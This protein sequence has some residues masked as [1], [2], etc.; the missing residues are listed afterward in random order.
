[1]WPDDFNFPNAEPEHPEAD[2]AAF[3]LNALDGPEHRAVAQHVAQCLHCQEVLLGFQGMAARLVESAPQTPLPPGLKARVLAAV[4][5][6]YDARP[7]PAMRAP[8]AA[9]PPPDRRWSTRRLRRWLA[10]AAIGA[11]SLLLAASAGFI[12][13]QQR[14]I[15]RLAAAAPAAAVAGI[16]AETADGSTAPTGPR[17]AS[18]RSDA[19]AAFAPAAV[20]GD[21]LFTAPNQDADAR[22]LN[23]ANAEQVDLVRREMADVVEATVLSAQSETKKLAMFSPMGT[24]PEAKGV[25]M[26]DPGGHQGVLMVSGMPVDSYQIWLARADKRMLVGRIVV[27][28]DNDGNGV[29]RLEL[30]ES[31]FDFQQVALLPDERN[32]P[33]VPNGEKF[34]TA[35]IIGGPPLPSLNR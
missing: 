28:A 3:A 12:V 2:L 27:N 14:E 11:L 5:R 29:Q 30:D 1:M 18:G 16:A 7:E 23:A 6:P 33:T 25:L 8:A 21:P 10:P 22:S 26:V 35:R 34:L 9:L 19:A 17:P 15:N 13:L 32:G 20:V 24:E 4:T 31:V